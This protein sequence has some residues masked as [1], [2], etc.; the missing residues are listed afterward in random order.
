MEVSSHAIAQKK[1]FPVKYSA[2][3]FT[4][5]SQDH[6]D[7]H[8][9]MEDYFN[10]KKELFEKYSSPDAYQL[11]HKTLKKKLSGYD[12]YYG[13]NENVEVLERT[14]Q[15]TKL[16]ISIDSE[17]REYTTSIVGDYFCENLTAAIMVYHHFTK[18]WPTEETIAKIPP[19][20]GRFENVSGSS[21][22]Q[23][24]PQVIVDYAHTPDAI[25]KTCEAIKA[26][27]DDPLTVLF[28][29]GGDRDPSKRP[30]MLKSALKASDFVCVTSD[31]P[32]TEEPLDIIGDVMD[33]AKENEIKRIHIEPDRKKAIEHIIA[34][35]PAP[36]VILIAGKGHEDY[37][38][39][40]TRKVSFD[41]RVVAKKCL[42]KL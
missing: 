8:K 29:C 9:T 15:Q 36:C 24:L 40:G 39:I 23:P 20:P 31:N 12:H 25:E 13:I 17:S 35:T 11:I 2:A 6:L 22:S 41:D 28:G 42:A 3:V 37:Q 33:G 5:F 10:A 14:L 18:Q 4:S 27:S 38:I 19:V 1:L 30:L 21:E 32:R 7:F 34:K 26:L 16:R